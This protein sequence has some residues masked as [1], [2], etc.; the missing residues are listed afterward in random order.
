M[1][2]TKYESSGPC[3]FRRDFWI[4][5]FKNLFLTPWPTYATKWNSLNNFGRG[6]PR[7]HSFEVRSKSNDWFQM[8][9][10]LSK[11]V[12]GRRTTTDDG[13]RPVTIAHTEHFVLRLA[14]NYIC[15]FLEGVFCS[16]TNVLCV[17]DLRITSVKYQQQLVVLG[18]QIR[19]FW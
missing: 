4:L 19:S 9:R 5:H 12:Y 17:G 15:T 11:K 1:L 8:R 14:K 18:D 6:P 16:P 10:C 7:D 3:S 2:Y 13:H